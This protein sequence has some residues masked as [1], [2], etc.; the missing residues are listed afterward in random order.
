ML[1]QQEINNDADFEST[2][3]K[4]L[5]INSIKEIILE[6]EKKAN[7]ER[8]KN[9]KDPELKKRKTKGG[10]KK[11]HATREEILRAI[12]VLKNN[13]YSNLTDD[14][15]AE[16]VAWKSRRHAVTQR[17]EALKQAA[18]KENTTVHESIEDSWEIRMRMRRRKSLKRTE[19]DLL[20]LPL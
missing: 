17:F 4:K 6:Y 8:D 15:I 10:S 13:Q 11:N 16:M 3:N 5:R 7:E 12:D 19:S 1:F 9:W 18:S 14:D 20:N 2:T